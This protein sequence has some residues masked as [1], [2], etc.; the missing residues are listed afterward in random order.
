MRLNRLFRFALLAP[1][2]LGLLL[3][4]GALIA[5]AGGDQLLKPADTQ[6]LFADKVY[7][8]GQSAPTQLRNSG[9]V[10]F[11]DGSYV[12]ATLVD[13]SGYSSDVQAK[14]QAYFITEIPLKI[15]GHDLPAGI[16]GVGFVADN[17]FIVTDVGAHDLFTVDSTTDE[18]MK[19]PTPL[20]VTA[21]PAGGYRL[22]SGRRY[23]P[24]NK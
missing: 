15:G 7:Y 9:G 17:K 1:L 3:A 18:A 2:A 21:D 12:L 24:F 16:Y 4:P 5:Q 23:V 22:Y 10:K 8:K 11:S 20:Q 14:Y 6:K 19:R 13:N